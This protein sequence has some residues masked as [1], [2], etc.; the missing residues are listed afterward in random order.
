MSGTEVER[1][2]LV[3]RLP[4]G[5]GAVTRRT[6]DQGYLVVGEVEVRLRRAD[7]ETLLTIKAGRGLERAEEEISI[8]P[9]RFDRLWPLTEGRR[10]HKVRHLLDGGIE[11]DVY[12]GA[13]APLVVAEI[14]FASPEAAAQWSPPAWLGAEVTG[15]ATYANQALAGRAAPRRGPASAAM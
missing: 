2:F 4:D 14:E 8:E 15:D 12:E 7:A 5:L 6:I 10:L 9:E 13:L 1:K 11:L 3:E